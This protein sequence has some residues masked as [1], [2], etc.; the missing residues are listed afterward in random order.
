MAADKRHILLIDDDLDMHEVTRLVLEPLGFRVSCA[1]TVPAGVGVLE[2]DPVDLLL[3]D[4]MLATPSEGLELADRIRADEKLSNLPI[5]LVSSA[6]QM[7]AL[8]AHRGSGVVGPRPGRFLEKPLDARQLRQAVV[9]ALDGN[10]GA[11]L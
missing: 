9:E 8:E 11:P 6:P 7:S 4:I 2:S 5:I 1:T 10:E 3:L